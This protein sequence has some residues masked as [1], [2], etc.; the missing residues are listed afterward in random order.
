MSMGLILTPGPAMAGDEGGGEDDSAIP[1]MTPT[2]VTGNTS[3]S[4]GG[5]PVPLLALAIFAAAAAS[6]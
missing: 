1:V 4:A 3:S 5:M 2:L 6:I